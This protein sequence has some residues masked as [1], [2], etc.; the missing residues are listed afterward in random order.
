MTVPKTGAPH[1]LASPLVDSQ[2]ALVANI[3]PPNIPTQNIPT[4]SVIGFP[5][6]ILPFWQQVKCIVEWAQLG[7]SKVVCVANV[8]MLTE[9]TTDRDLAAVIH[10]ADL[11]TPDGMPLVWMIQML[12]RAHQDRVAG[13]D[14]MQAVCQVAMQQGV[15]V[16]FLGSEARILK[17][18]RLRLNREFPH[19]KIAGMEPLPMLSVPIAVD[20]TVIEQV[21]QT[22]AGIV[23]LAL[24]CPK[25]EKWMAA[26]QGQINAVMIGVGGVFPIYAG[27]QKRAPAFIRSGGLEWLYRLAQEPTR[28]WGR[29]R[30]TIPPFIWMA[31]QQLLKRSAPVTALVEAE[32]KPA[33]ELVAATTGRNSRRG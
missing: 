10:G 1:S 14:L 5:V 30:K 23:F 26:Y 20:P 21:N 13:M 9:A 25:Q 31:V 29:Y 19:L 4:Q 6:T 33:P 7:L 28:L 3:L 24:G 11:V 22:G 27:I 16:Y 2:A 18:M 12:Q 17:Q 32:M 15:S 8:H